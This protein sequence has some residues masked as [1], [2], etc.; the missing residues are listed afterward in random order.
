MTT[1]V[2]FNHIILSLIELFKALTTI[3]NDKLKAVTAKDLDALNACIKDEQ[4]QVLKLRGLD[5]KREQV[6]ADLGYENHTFKEII[7]LLP[8]NQKKDSKELFTLLE[9]ATSDFHAVN[10]SV[11]TALEVNL[12]FINTA[13]GKL[14]INPDI[15]Q[16]QM[17]SG[18]NFKNR[19]A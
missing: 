18:N 9:Q 13:L 17:P 16:K 2:E 19:F 3:E 5:K 12:H 6:Q 14:N 4:V 15:V 1:I 7:A 10:D 11:K 8:E